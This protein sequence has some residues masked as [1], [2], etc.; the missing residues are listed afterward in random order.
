MLTD[1]INTL[2]L[3]SKALP[4]YE[5]YVNSL[6]CIVPVVHAKVTINV[7]ACILEL[8]DGRPGSEDAANIMILGHE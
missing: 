3:V 6:K 2:W 5:L 1:S 4:K 8:N 7:T